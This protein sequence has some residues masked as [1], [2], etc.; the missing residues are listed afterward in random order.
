MRL[1]Q[2]LRTAFNPALVVQALAVF[3][4]EVL[5]TCFAIDGAG[6]E[7][8]APT[9]TRAIDSGEMLVLPFP[10]LAFMGETE[11]WLGCTFCMCCVLCTCT[12]TATLDCDLICTGTV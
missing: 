2:S 12:G 3:D 6:G 11:S 9:W 5:T 4:V 8:K 7:G 1:A 10:R